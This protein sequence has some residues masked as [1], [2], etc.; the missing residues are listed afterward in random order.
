MA[1][2]ESEG[3]E[4]RHRV[5][6]GMGRGAPYPADKDLGERR[7]ERLELSSGVRCGF[8]AANAFWSS[9]LEAI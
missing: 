7:G 1:S 9:H 5:G 3:I 6:W 4:L 2:A 8:P